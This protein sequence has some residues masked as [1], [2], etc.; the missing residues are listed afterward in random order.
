ME[1][2]LRGDHNVSVRECHY[3]NT[4]TG[5]ESHGPIRV[6]KEVAAASVQAPTKVPVTVTPAQETA[7]AESKEVKAALAEAGRNKYAAVADDVKVNGISFE[8]AARA[9]RGAS[10][11]LQAVAKNMVVEYYSS[12]IL[13]LCFQESRAVDPSIGDY[14]RF[15]LRSVRSGLCQCH[16][17]QR[18]IPELRHSRRRPI[19]LKF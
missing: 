2:G 6:E 4:S 11:S 18:I 13:S 8:A 5:L 1:Q 19:N 3:S 15:G 9:M 7:M 10:R 16:S 17:W 12:L 14:L